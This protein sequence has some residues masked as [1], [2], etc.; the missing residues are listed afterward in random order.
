MK[1]FDGISHALGS[2][3]MEKGMGEKEER[4]GTTRES[5]K[6]GRRSPPGIP[7]GVIQASKLNPTHQW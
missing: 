7:T 2:C 1:S 3:N 5:R 4:M 6:V